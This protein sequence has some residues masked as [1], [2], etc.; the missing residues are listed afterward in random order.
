MNLLLV[1]DEQ[2]IADFICEGLRA[3]NFSVTHCADGHKGY[4]AASSQAFDVII[5][6]IMLPGRDGLDILASLRQIGVETPV[7]LLTARNELGDRVQG[8]EMG[9]DDYLA[10]PFYVEE[11]NARIQALLRRHSGRAQHLLEVGSLQ[12]DCINRSLHCQG[13]SVELTSREFSLLEYLMRS[14]NQVLTRGQLLE[15]VWGYDFDPCTNVVDVCIKRIRRKI[16]SL[17]GA[18]KMVGAIE[19][20]RGTGYRLS[21]G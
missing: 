18:G 16:A 15:H 8:L 10:K 14:P 7:I 9:A 2:K 3:K 5:L 20:V 12:L 11:L 4:E 13:Q 6:D 21:A 19:S 1:E 17:E